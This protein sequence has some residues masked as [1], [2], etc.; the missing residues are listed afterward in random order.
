M[1]VTVYFAYVN[2]AGC[3]L[4]VC[5]CVCVCCV[6]ACVVC[7]FCVSICVSCV[8]CVPLCV[9]VCVYAHTTTQQFRHEPARM[10]TLTLTHTLPYRR[11]PHGH[12]F[13]RLI[14]HMCACSRVRTCVHGGV[15][16]CVCVC[17]SVHGVCV[18]ARARARVCV[19][20]H[21]HTAKI[22]SSGM[23]PRA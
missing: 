14:C 2:M 13:Y 1:H 17:S 8:F 9:F 6:C 3:V 5:V 20:T 4:C 15:C 12:V 10:I 18:C 21:Y 22:H 7:A 11:D 16:V 19:C 23:N